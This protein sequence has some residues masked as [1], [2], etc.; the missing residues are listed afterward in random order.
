[1]KIQPENKVIV[2][3]YYPFTPIRYTQISSRNQ[4]AHHPFLPRRSRPTRSP[5]TLHRKSTTHFTHPINV[6]YSS[7]T[8]TSSLFPTASSSLD[9]AIHV[10]EPPCASVAGG[11]GVMA[12]SASEK[13]CVTRTRWLGMRYSAQGLT[14]LGSPTVWTGGEDRID[15][16]GRSKEA[17]KT[18]R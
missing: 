18:A 11:T 8:T 12:L 9:S 3:N 16:G 10:W 7:N 6:K 1:M 13:A 4:K 15:R 17:W 2:Y 14:K 5:N